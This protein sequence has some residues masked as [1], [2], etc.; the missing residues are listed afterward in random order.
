MFINIYCCQFTN[1][2]SIM[3][4][5]KLKKYALSYYLPSSLKFITKLH[6]FSSFLRFFKLILLMWKKIQMKKTIWFEINYEWFLSPSGLDSLT[7]PPLSTPTHLYLFSPQFHF[8]MLRHL[9]FNFSV[10]P[11]I[12]SMK[13]SVT[14]LLSN[15]MPSLWSPLCSTTL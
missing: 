7:S 13:S 12:F 2:V 8:A 5:Y 1:K 6:A 4:N 11:K 9:A 15:P 10:F 14:S 3:K